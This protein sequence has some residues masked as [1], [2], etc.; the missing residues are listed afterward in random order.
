LPSQPV[1]SRSLLGLIQALDFELLLLRGSLAVS[2]QELLARTQQLHGWTISEEWFP[3]RLSFRYRTANPCL[4]VVQRG[5]C[6]LEMPSVSSPACYLKDQGHNAALLP[7]GVHDITF[8]Q[9]PLRLVRFLLPPGSVFDR[10]SGAG[11]RQ[12]TSLRL[13]L[14]LLL[15]LERLLEQSLRPGTPVTT[16]LE[17]GQILLDYVRHQFESAGCSISVPSPSAIP[18]DPLQALEY[19]LQT[20]LDQPLQLS[21]LARAAALSPR[22]LQEICRERLDCSPMDWLRALR[23]E[24]FAAALRDPARSDQ[25]VGL[26][27]KHFQLPAS[28]ATRRA[29]TKRFGA[30]P[31]DYRRSHL[32]HQ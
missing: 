8:T 20:R 17:L 24:S 19:W 7:E 11:L 2:E 1:R 23:L 25:T 21:D 14:S 27:L 15:P 4:L 31:S 18:T 5:R 9:A 12:A 22:R 28:L 3:T 29:F 26:L 13:D 30:S 16:R 32:L 10:G 6:I